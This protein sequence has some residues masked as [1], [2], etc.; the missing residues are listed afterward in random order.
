MTAFAAAQLPPDIDTLEKLAAW[1]GLALARANPA[2]L[3]TE[4]ELFDDNGVK[5]RD[6]TQRAAQ[7]NVYFIPVTGELRLLCRQ[8]ILMHPDYYAGGRSWSHA[9]EFIGSLELP[10]AF[11][12]AS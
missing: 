7:A 6:L 1:V 11:L 5:L 2:N 9:Q 8:S 12:R 3:V 10:T 4:G